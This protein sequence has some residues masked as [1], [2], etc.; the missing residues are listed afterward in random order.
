MLRWLARLWIAFALLL[1]TAA[2]MAWILTAD[3]VHGISILE[4]G[5]T[6]DTVIIGRGALAYFR[7]SSPQLA[8]WEAYYQLSPA[9]APATTRPFQDSLW[10]CDTQLIQHEKLRRTSDDQPLLVLKSGR[11]F[12]RYPNR[13]Q[14]FVKADWHFE[15][16]LSL[17]AAGS[18]LTLSPLIVAR[19]RQRAKR[20]AAGLCT[21]CGYDLRGAA[22]RCPEC[23]EA[24]PAHL[25]P[26]AL[27]RAVA[28]IAGGLTLIAAG[29]LATGV[30]TLWVRSPT[31]G[32]L[33]TYRSSWWMQF[34]IYSAD[35]YIR[36]RR[37]PTRDAEMG[38]SLH[39]EEA[40][41]PSIGR[42]V[43]RTDYMA[44]NMPHL[45]SR[46]DGCAICVDTFPDGPNGRAVGF[47]LCAPNWL[48]LLIISPA[49]LLPLW[50]WV[51]PWRSKP[52]R[53][54]CTPPL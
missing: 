14:S 38:R 32:E 37:G 22:K 28:R 53:A 8:R 3:T 45:L 35:G 44:G 34:E 20:R 15:V 25:H 21:R 40:V 18:L 4:T 1:A 24:R 47:Y 39:P 26:N 16:S 41:A 10:S 52:A 9:G 48:Y 19:F 17:I 31:N 29:L 5:G 12:A 27:R 54:K 49:I 46:F 36:L 2:A 30:L 50:T 51:R 43:H 23:G 42:L 33:L 11:A 7:G 13:S 6:D